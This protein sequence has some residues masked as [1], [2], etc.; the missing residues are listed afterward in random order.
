MKGYSPTVA[1]ERIEDFIYVI[2]GQKVMLDADL[3]RL[4]GVPTKVLNQAVKRNLERFPHDF[5]FQLTGAEFDDLKLHM[6]ASRNRS[7][8]VTGSQK[9][10]DPRY[11]PYA[12]TEHGAIMAANVLNSPS[13]VQMSVFVVRAFI[14]MRAALTDNRELARKLAQLEKELK[15]RLDVHEVAIVDILRR[16]MDI[17]DPPALPEPQKERMGFR[18]KELRGAYRAGGKRLRPSSSGPRRDRKISNASRNTEAR[19]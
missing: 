1:L 14:R 9:H 11:L 4:Y 8:S 17:I 5:V 15:D 6:A 12:F 18:V 10:R 13:A 16:I 2:R 19:T 7:Q 3:A